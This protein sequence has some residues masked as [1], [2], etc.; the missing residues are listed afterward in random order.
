MPT[1]KV[2]TRWY[3]PSEPGAE[4]NRAHDRECADIAAAVHA[5]SEHNGT[6]RRAMRDEGWRWEIVSAAKV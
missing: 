6:L 5:E 4:F 2:V 1:Y 3:D